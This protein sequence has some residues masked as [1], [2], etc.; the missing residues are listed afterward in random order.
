MNNVV[1]KNH[2]F[3]TA[4]LIDTKCSDSV[5]LANLREPWCDGFSCNHYSVSV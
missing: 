3:K 4:R 2:F 5:E 1:L